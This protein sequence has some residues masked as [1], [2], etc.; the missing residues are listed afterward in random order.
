MKPYRSGTL[1]SIQGQQPLIPRT[2]SL[3]ELKQAQQ[4]KEDLRSRFEL[5]NLKSPRFSF[6]SFAPSLSKPA[7]VQQSWL[8]DPTP[9]GTPDPEEAGRRDGNG[10]FPIP[11]GGKNRRN[12]DGRIFGLQKRW[13]W[14]LLAVAAVV[15]LGL[16]IGVAVGVSQS[17]A[18]SSSHSSTSGGV[19]NG[20]DTSASSAA[21]TATTTTGTTAT[22]STTSATATST[23]GVDCPAG[24]GTTY[25]VPGSTVQFLHLCGIDYSGDDEAT[26]LGSVQTNS[27]ADCM[28]NCA[29]TSGCTGCGWGYVDGDSLFEH[30]C[31]LKSGLKQSHTAD[32]GWAFAIII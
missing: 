14:G 2:P 30:T 27:M 11:P 1:G 10:M 15:I 17:K 18:N 19:G 28:D 4:E 6:T 16:V 13:F 24:N 5:L 9:P 29:G 20:T 22:T 31:W 26:D 25:T 32:S 8:R 3:T 23:G 21:A 12:G 7:P